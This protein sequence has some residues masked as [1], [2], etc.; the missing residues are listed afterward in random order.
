MTKSD[1]TA[2][3]GRMGLLMELF[4]KQLSENMVALYW[5]ALKDLP[6]VKFEEAC[7]HIVRTHKW[8]TF[9]KPAEFIEYAD[10]PEDIEV[11]A[12]VALRNLEQMQGDI[13]YYETAIFKDPILKA[14]VDHYGGWTKCI[15]LTRT[16]PDREYSFWAK[17]FYKI[18]VNFDKRGVVPKTM[19]G[20]GEHERRGLEF[21]ESFALA[22]PDR[23]LIPPPTAKESVRLYHEGAEPPE[24]ESPTKKDFKR[25]AIN[26]GEKGR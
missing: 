11:R 18:Y 4:G 25:I 8:N 26:T 2:F 5:S 7:L 3:S 1:Y 20:V 13:G 6:W 22:H 15:N 24:I 10:P 23:K 17:E 12:V 14:V 21:L 9:P 16:M 19:I